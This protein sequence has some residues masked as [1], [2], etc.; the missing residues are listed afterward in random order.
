M[1][2]YVTAGES[3]GSSLVAI[4]TGLPAGLKIDR[5][6]LDGLMA[7]R[8]GGYGRS[9]R[10][11]MERDRATF[12]SGVR[13]GVT[14]GNPISLR[15]A[16]KAKTL[17]KLPPVNR[18]R[19]GHADLAGVLKFGHDADAR[20]VLERSSARETAVRTGVGALA[21]IFLA[22]FGIE[23]FGHVVRLGPVKF[24]SAKLG[25]GKLSANVRDSSPFFS[26]DPA[27]DKKARAAVDA[28]AEDGDTL[29]GLIE[30]VATGV[31]PGLGSNVQVDRRLD[32]QWAA[33]L[34]AIPAMK[35]VEF[36]IGFSAATRRGSKVHDRI[37]QNRDGLLCRPTNRAGGLEG[38]MSN[39][40][41]LIARIAMKP[42]STLRKP[43]ES[44]DLRTKRRQDAHFERSDVTAVPAASV[45]AEAVTAFVLA[46]AFRE[47]FGGD[48][49]GEVRRN[50][51]GYLGQIAAHW[52]PG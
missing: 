49:M 22:E 45:I 34:M 37:R 25:P 13:K 8:Q 12:L 29:G 28:A 14:T 52:Q 1:L 11:K 27:R 50:Y 16:N 10:Q 17:S 36:G 47:K 46:R 20:D 35:G 19:P 44:V 32:G 33:A 24:G 39:G 23:V 38:G 40:Q 6:R 5:Q 51:D 30:I 4:V 31:P 18:P 15:V 3:H 7:R 48:S 2:E 9:V 43:L 26:L 42:L 41:P 21:A